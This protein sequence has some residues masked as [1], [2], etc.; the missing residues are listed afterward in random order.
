M[1][2]RACLCRS[3]FGWRANGRD[4][5]GRPRET[6]HAALSFYF[7]I[8]EHARPLVDRARDYFL[9]LRNRVLPFDW[10]AR[11]AIALGIL[12]HA[13]PQ[14]SAEF[15]GDCDDLRHRD[16]MRQLLLFLPDWPWAFLRF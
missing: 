11:V 12:R 16:V 7:S 5:R 2:F 15:Q 8:R 4:A 13:R 9:G 3:D 1:S 14:G 6:I 10:H